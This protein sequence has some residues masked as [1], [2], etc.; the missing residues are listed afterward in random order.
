MR[1][2]I[3][4]SDSLIL[5][6]NTMVDTSN[7]FGRYEQVNFGEMACESDARCIGVYDASC[8]KRGPFLLL[9]KGFMTSSRA[10]NCI[11]KKKHYGT[12]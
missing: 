4:L 6:E 8:D 10:T 5:Q 9:Q 11:Y 2:Y 12:L 7:T 1:N 3:G